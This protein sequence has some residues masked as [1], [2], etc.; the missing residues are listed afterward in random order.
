MTGRSIAI[1][2]LTLLFASAAHGGVR[3]EVEGL[4]SDERDNVMA[5]LAIRQQGQRDDLN[6]AMV[7]RLH[8]QA[9]TDVRNAMQPFGWYSPVLTDSSLVG[10]APNWTAHYHVDAGAYTAVHTIDIQLTGDGAEHEAF[11][12][13]LR[14]ATRRLTVGE[15][16][17]HADYEEAKKLLTDAA[18]AG[19]FLDAYWTVSELRVNP[20]TR[21][22]DIVLH[23]E[24]GPRYS[25]GEVT[26]D[27]ADDQGLNA[28]FV[29]RY[30][31]LKVGEPFDPQ[32]LLDQQFALS[33]LGYFQS[34]EIVPQRSLADAEHRV[35]LVIHTTPRNKHR[36]EA[37]A[38]YGTDTGA[39]VSV[40]T[41][42]RQINQYGHN[43]DGDARLS[44]IKNTMAA[45]YRVPQGGKPGENIS[46]TALGQTEQLADGDSIKYTLG[47]SLN[48]HPGEWARRVYM[49]FTHEESELGNQRATADLM[50]PGVSFTRTASD[51][52]I[53]ARKGWFLFA[54]LH[55]AQEGL[56]SNTTF[57]RAFV[58]TRG[59]YSLGRG[60]RLLAR[61]D[62]GANVQKRFS[63]LPASQR[64]FAGGDQSVRGYRYQS[65]G[66]RDSNGDVIGGQ[67]L[68]V[69]SGEIEQRIR[70]SWGAA[71]FLDDGGADDRFVPELFFGTG[72]GVRYRSPV[73]TFQVDL[74]HPLTGDAEGQL[75]GLRLHIGVR[76]GL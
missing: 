24:T 33:D 28:A 36:Y 45:N 30:V 63:D 35:P 21:Q 32:K 72:A 22:A 75:L 68:T 20:D 55:G 39:R 3:V 42:W 54:D 48:R 76:V 37:G 58:Q 15:R 10:T 31:T 60:T 49:E 7:E 50:T 8:D 53:F 70:G 14:R 11:A 51:D 59:V 57:V 61:M 64:F 62:L 29:Q 25:F 4:G 13:A 38:G 66:T 73:G 5:R 47:A 41:E 17:K 26:I 18:Y 52:P 65:I 74:A 69:F 44:Q 19:G 16:L 56:L 1:L 40:G 46:F 43:L 23:M 2:L 6:D 9:A 27:N 67:Y 34:V 71:V 12:A